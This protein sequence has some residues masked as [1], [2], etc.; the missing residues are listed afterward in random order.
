MIDFSL[1]LIT[2]RKIVPD[3]NIIGAIE[4]ALIG[5]VRAVQLR[6]K[7]L[8]I[9]ELLD[10][11]YR[12]R[13]LTERYSAR[14]FINDRVDVAVAVHAD[15]VH[16]GRDSIPPYAA[17]RVSWDLLVGVSTHSFEEAI[18]AERGGADFITF[19][20][21]FPTPSK[22]LFGEPLGLNKLSE[23]C[24]LVSLPVFAIGGIK[25]EHLK[26]VFSNGAKGVAV[27]SAILGREDI[28]SAAEKF[29]R[30]LK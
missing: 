24:S 28:K 2:D 4:E 9:R 19:G 16:L 8:K 14:L 30:C 21:V 1:Y 22:L 5:G 13:E 25:P 29:M 6:E 27:I 12:L 11:A 7:D 10:M 3:G 26:D 17:K 20:P 23:V 18:E 15:G